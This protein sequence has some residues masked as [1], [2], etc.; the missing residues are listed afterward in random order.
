MLVAQ[1]TNKRQ[2]WAPQIPDQD[3]RDAQTSVHQQCYMHA[4]LTTSA[5]LHACSIYG[6]CSHLPIGDDPMNYT[7]QANA[8]AGPQQVCKHV[9][10]GVRPAW[11]LLGSC[12][13]AQE[14]AVLKEV[15]AASGARVVREWEQG[16]TH[17]VC[18]LDGQGA[19]KWVHL[20]CM[21]PKHRSYRLLG[22]CLHQ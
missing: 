8:P 16:V 19:A 10:W 20:L 21:P 4:K 14:A 2:V 13:E 9:P 22:L 3:A 15:A 17:I 6:R 5:T 18:H 12:L 11:K 7:R 1:A